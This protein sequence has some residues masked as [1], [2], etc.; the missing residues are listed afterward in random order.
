MSHA[1]EF[2]INSSREHTKQ[3]DQS[4]GAPTGDAEWGDEKMGQEIASQEIKEG[5]WD[6]DAEAPGFKDVSAPAEGAWDTGNNGAPGFT[7]STAPAD[8]G[9]AAETAGPAE[10]AEPADSVAEL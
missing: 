8:G 6:A 2:L 7:D 1:R 10:P 4:W 3:S 9:A 5:G